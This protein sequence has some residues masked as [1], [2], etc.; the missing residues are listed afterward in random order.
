MSKEKLVIPEKVL[1][2]LKQIFSK[3]DPI[4]NGGLDFEILELLFIRKDPITKI[5]DSYINQIKTLQD[6]E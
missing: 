3:N 5:I 4:M 2:L 6:G 1:E